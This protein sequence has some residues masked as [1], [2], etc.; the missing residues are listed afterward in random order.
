MIVN[1][2]KIF[3]YLYLWSQTKTIIL[4]KKQFKFRERNCVC[5]AIHGKNGFAQVSIKN[6]KK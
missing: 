6:I 3:F 2:K 4:N 1:R 5:E